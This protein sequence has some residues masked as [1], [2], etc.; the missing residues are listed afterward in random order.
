MAQQQQQQQRNLEAA[1]C[2]ERLRGK[3]AEGGVEVIFSLAATAGAGGIVNIKTRGDGSQEVIKFCPAS[4]TEG[5][6]HRTRRWV[7]CRLCQTSKHP[8]MVLTVSEC[9]N[10]V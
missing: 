6:A 5:R 4:V 10:M 3:R 2:R 9:V 1:A 8:N 7:R